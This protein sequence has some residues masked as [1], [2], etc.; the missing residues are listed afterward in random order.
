[1]AG[2]KTFDPKKAQQFVTQQPVYS[3]ENRWKSILDDFVALG[4][5]LIF[6]ENKLAELQEKRLTITRKSAFAFQQKHTDNPWA[7]DVIEK[8]ANGAEIL[9]KDGYVHNNGSVNGNQLPLYP[10]SIAPASVVLYHLCKLVNKGILFPIPF[11]IFDELCKRKGV[12]YTLLPVFLA[13]KAAEIVAVSETE[14]IEIDRKLATRS[15]RPLASADAGRLVVNSSLEGAPNDKEL[16]EA[17]K[18]MYTTI[19]DASIWQIADMLLNGL[20]QAET[21]AGGKHALTIVKTDV[22]AAYQKC[23]LTLLSV[24]KAV[25]SFEKNG[26]RYV[27]LLLTANFGQQGGGNQWE[28]AA[29]TLHFEL[30]RALRG[31]GLFS[32]KFVDDFMF[33]VPRY[34]YELIMQGLNADAELLLADNALSAEKTEEGR[35]K[36]LLGWTAD[37]DEETLSLKLT[38]LY[39]IAHLLYHVLVDKHGGYDLQVG[40]LYPLLPLQQL[41][42]CVFRAE[43][44]V[45]TLFGFAGPLLK[46]VAVGP[47]T[48]GA[49]VEM[50]RLNILSIIAIHTLRGIVKWLFENT[51]ELSSPIQTVWYLAKRPGESREERSLRLKHSPICIATCECDASGKHDGFQGIGVVIHAPGGTS[52]AWLQVAVPLNFTVLGKSGKQEAVDINVL[53]LMGGVLSVAAT[54]SL[55]N[56]H[57]LDCARGRLI[58]YDTDSTCAESFAVKPRAS[59][60]LYFLLIQL[61]SMITRLT[62][63]HAIPHWVRRCNV[64]RADAISKNFTESAT[65]LEMQQEL[66]HVPRLEMPEAFWPSLQKLLNGMST[67]H[68][69]E[70]QQVST[71]ASSLSTMSFAAQRA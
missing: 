71:L 41:A 14:I 55:L 42:G 8:L 54:I 3:N 22:A 5:P 4:D 23:L 59:T 31:I 70:A 21:L 12:E 11:K 68:S 65:Q 45:P 40:G 43:H 63:A 62:G 26:E 47:C 24:L 28:V 51:N 10:P 39:R 27:G 18:Q 30:D 15:T 69:L 60:N 32:L 19:E 67:L 58:V 2:V 48:I 38:L 64:Q 1:V 16:T 52:A 13:A 17:Y 20:R 57:Q 6:I 29:K 35:R 33:V 49:R 37:L 36:H 66:A 9:V 46:S 25:L 50:C 7:N 53:E 61:Q 34:F 44:V 56:H